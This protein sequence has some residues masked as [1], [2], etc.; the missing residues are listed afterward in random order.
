LFEFP[1]SLQ[2]AFLRRTHQANIAGL[3]ILSSK[4]CRKAIRMVRWLP[5]YE[6]A[7]LSLPMRGQAE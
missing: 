4:D 7:Q 6:A 2:P 5:Y 1:S 3:V